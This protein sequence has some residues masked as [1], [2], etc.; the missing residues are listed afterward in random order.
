LPPHDPF[1]PG[2]EREN[3]A[4][5][6]IIPFLLIILE[7]IRTFQLINYSPYPK[8]EDVKGEPHF[9]LQGVG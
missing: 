3:V 6:I 1:I 5:N 2:I 8:N 9:V 4:F 7:R